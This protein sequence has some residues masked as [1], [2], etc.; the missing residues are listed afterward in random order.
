MQLGRVLF[1]SYTPMKMSAILRRLC[2]RPEEAPART[3]SRA[4]GAVADAHCADHPHNRS[5]ALEGQ[6]L[7]LQC[8]WRVT[9]DAQ[10]REQEGGDRE[11]PWAE[12]QGACSA[13]LG[14]RPAGRRGN[15]GAL[16]RGPLAQFRLLLF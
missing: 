6:V 16:L 2:Q 5:P 12:G 3:P 14:L 7:T 8:P 11:R 9:L 1:T 10:H 13:S 15:K 4:D